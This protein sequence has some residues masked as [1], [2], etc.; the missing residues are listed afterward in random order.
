DQ[1]ITLATS[2]LDPRGDDPPDGAS[3]HDNIA[4]TSRGIPARRSSY[5]NAQGGTVALSPAML[6]GLLDLASR[7]AFDV[8]EIA[9]GSHPSKSRR[10]AAAGASF[11]VDVIDGRQV[12]GL[13]G[14]EE[15]RFMDGCRAGGASDVRV[16]G[17]HIHCGWR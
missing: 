15:Q 3:A 1:R 6:Q 2:H 9:G 14:E 7:F 13:G 17:L 11:D 16:E 8:A 5:A 10:A 4:D 12:L